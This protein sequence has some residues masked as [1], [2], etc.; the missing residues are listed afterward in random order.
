MSHVSIIGTG[1][2]G[3]AIG[4]VLTKGGHTVQRLNTSDADTQLHGELVILAVPYPAVSDVVAARG[5][6]LAGKVVVDITNPLN[7]QTFDSLTVPADSS[8]TAEIAAALP[9][10][11]VL[12]AF[13]TTFAATL[14][15]G[16]VGGLPTTVLVA[17]DDSDAKSLLA[18]VVGSGGLRVVDAGPLR[19]ARELEAIGFLQITLAAAQRVSWT[20]GFA[21]V[22]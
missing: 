21:L 17:G 1:N 11:T 6:Q 2:M 4:D 10:S 7:F 3:T 9:H 19:R 15:S 14:T 13:N 22:E 5:D 18:D 16:T 12:K 8:A 20:G